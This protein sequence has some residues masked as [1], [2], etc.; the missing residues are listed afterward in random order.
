MVSFRL[1]GKWT[2][3]VL[4]SALL[5]ALLRWAELP[6]AEMLGPM[7]AATF[8]ALRGAAPDMPRWA[9]GGAQAV[10]GCMLAM[11]ITPST[12]VS[13]AKDWPIM[14]TVVA[15]TIGAGGLTGFLLT[16]FGSLPGD[17]AAWGSSPGGAAAMTAMAEAHGADLR[18]V[19]FM[20]YLRLFVVVLTASVVTR[21]A[22]GH[23][24]DT[25][26]LHAWN[27][28]LD[29]PLVPLIQ[30]LALAA[31]GVAAGG[32]LRI[33][34]GA[35]LLP[36]LIGATLNATGLVTLIVPPWLLWLA[37]ASLGWYIG[38]RFTRQTVLHA[39][40]AIPQMLLGTALL[41][42][43]CG[44]SA[45]VLTAWLDMDGLSA[46]L[47]T[48]PGGLDS[49]AIIAMGSGGDLPFI[50]ALQTLRLFAVVL[51]GPLVARL[52]CRFGRARA[53]PDARH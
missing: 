48:S 16:R 37:Y 50:L 26:A 7:V 34:A 12:L 9:F 51:T 35:L 33:P 1:L 21:L 28:G 45:W 8:F 10:I 32:R 13:L 3:L 22:L 23:A 41:I 46:F 17:T 38:L 49:I 15:M 19:A 44:V 18:M 4:V 27:P 24:L 42:A 31:C 53:T 6:A 30:T 2:S 14:L 39:M 40:Q 25:P 20:Q 11:A 36:M 43:L 47:A 29:T 52:I 5:A